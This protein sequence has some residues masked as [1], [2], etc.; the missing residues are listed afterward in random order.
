MNCEILNILYVKCNGEILC[1]DDFGERILLGHVDSVRTVDDIEALFTNSQYTHIRESFQK[2]VVPWPDVCE[3]CAFL[4]HND[5]FT[6]Y[7]AGKRLTKLQ[8]EPTLLCNLNCRCCTNDVQVQTRRKPHVMAAETYDRFLRALHGAGFRVDSL[9]YCGQG[10]PLLHPQIGELLA[11]TRE[12]YPQAWQRVITN[13]NVSYA[14]TLQGTSVDEIMVAGDGIRQQSYEQ[15]RV[16]GKIDK[17]VRFMADAVAD[18]QQGK[19]VVIWKYILFEFNDSD[20]EL[21]E[22]QHKAGELGVDSLLFVVTHSEFHSQRYPMEALA[23]LPIIIPQVATNAHPSFFDGVQQGVLRS[24]VL[25]SLKNRLCKQ[26][27]AHLDEVLL[28]PGNLLQL[29]GWAAATEPIV[30]I[31]LNLDGEKLGEVV[32]TDLRPDVEQVYPAF[33]HQPMG[34]RL[35]AHMDKEMPG[36]CTLQLESYGAGSRLLGRTTTICN[37]MPYTDME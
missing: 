35:S 8:L 34:F 7:I 2:G 31:Q 10:E 9:E 5:E 11:V 13:A 19:P 33:Q 32:P 15:Y 4:R 23:K 25:Q 17:V 27:R 16:K 26:Y 1:N 14:K 36:T 18:K 12:V 30:R 20:Q 22:A 6:D 37:F 28:F 3:H 21:I 29:R 24:P